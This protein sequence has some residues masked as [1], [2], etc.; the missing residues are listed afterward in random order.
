MSDSNL[1]ND[2]YW[3]AKP[4]AEKDRICRGKGAEPAGLC[5]GVHPVSFMLYPNS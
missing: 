1:K 5:H 3:W 4:T 2:E